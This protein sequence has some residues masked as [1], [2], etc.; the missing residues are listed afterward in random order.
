MK[1][2]FSIH[3][4]ITFLVAYATI[5]KLELSDEDVILMS[6]NYKVKINDF[7][8]IPNFYEARNRTIIQ[9]IK[10]LNVPKSFDDY[11]NEHVAGE[12]YIAYIDL[13][14]YYQ[15]MLVTNE[16]CR[17]FHFIE[18]GNSTYMEVD[19]IDDLTW[20]GKFRGVTFREKLFYKKSFFIS[21]L[22]ILKGSNYRLLQ[23]P[24]HYMAYVNL[25]NIRFFCFSDNAFF[26]APASKKIKLSPKFL[27]NLSHEFTNDII[28]KNDIIWIDEPKVRFTDLDSSFYYNAAAKALNILKKKSI[29]KRIYVKFRPN[30]KQAA[31]KQNRLIELLKLNHFEYEILPPWINLEVLFANSKNN[32]VIGVHST[33]LEY[34][35]MFGHQTYSIFDLFDEQPETFFD[36]MTGFKNNLK[37]LKND[38]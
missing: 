17:E 23:L 36:R 1:H 33:A 9:K 10:Y 32:M 25:K 28:I 15:K 22:R 27:E 8:V 37:S 30:I 11:I 29:N 7:K 34:A 20:P 35:H 14:S 5:K 3:S 4:N 24:Y 18:E 21:L 16:K 26:N 2:V 13:M 6:S 12:D 38:I 19:D 31:I